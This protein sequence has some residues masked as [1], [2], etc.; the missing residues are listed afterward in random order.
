MDHRA[1]IMW[2]TFGI[3]I[4]AGCKPSPSEV[5]L[6]KCEEAEAR[7]EIEEA[8]DACS[9]AVTTDPASKFAD[10]AQEKLKKLQ[11]EYD[12]AKK[13]RAEM[14]AQAIKNREQESKDRQAAQAARI[15]ALRRKVSAKWWGDEPDGECQAKGLP[16]YRKTYEGGL[17]AENETVALADGCAHLFGRHVDPSP[18]DNIFCCPGR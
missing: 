10:V 3:A 17:Y 11:P 14:E 12:K 18:N 15:E 8:W 2:I 9:V 13:A 5:W 1:G 7:G 4:V 16:P 6:Q